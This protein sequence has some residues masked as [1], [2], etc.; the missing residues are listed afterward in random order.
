MDKVL[1]RRD[2]L[3]AAGLA[4]AAG[5]LPGCTSA[6]KTQARAE[7]PNILFIMTDQQS[8]KTTSAYGSPYVHTPHMDSIAANGVRFEKSYCT[9][10]VCGPSR[11]SLVTSR[12]PHVTGVNVNGQTPDSSIPN[13]GEIFRQAGYT[14]AW[15]GKWHLPKSYPQGP[16]R[17]F[18]YLKVPEGTGFRLGSE[19]DGLVADEAIKFLRRKHDRPLLLGVSLHNPHDIC[20][21]VREKP[22]KHTNMDAFPPLPANF[23]IDPDE[24]EFISACRQRT[25]YGPENIYTKKWDNDQWRAYLCRYFR[26]VEEVDREIG[27]VLAALREQGLQDDTLIIFT[28]DHGEGMAAHHWVVK[29][30][31]YEEPVT[32]PFIVSFNGVTPAGAADNTH[33]VCG[34]DILPTMCDYGRVP[35]RQDFAG[36]S[37]RRLIEK[38][39]LRGREFVVTEL[40][41]DTKNPRVRGRMLRTQRYKYIAFSYGENREMLFDIEADPGET[42]NLAQDPSV[43][44]VLE[45]HRGLLRDWTAENNDEFAVPT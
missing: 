25:F 7:R 4:A 45:R 38:P 6:L 36:M 23:A 29:L 19:T 31:L 2:F 37:L 20:W 30:M 26:Y 24:P 8:L 42:R 35:L 13:M 28:S 34:L 21:W 14:T 16:I 12:M 5:S 32:V 39:S 44:N 1:N 43:R 33:L 3:K 9:A 17:G 41:P 40:Q 18:E 15:A 27:R 10:P 22:V 11:S